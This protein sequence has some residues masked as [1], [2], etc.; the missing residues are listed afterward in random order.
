MAAALFHNLIQMNHGNCDHWQIESAGTWASPGQPAAYEVQEILKTM[1]IDLS[2]HRSR[3]VSKELLQNFCLILTMERGQKESLSIEF[4]EFKHR[5]FMLSEMSGVDVSIK[6]PIGGTIEDFE[7]GLNDI[8][9]WLSR[10]QAQIK[11]LARCN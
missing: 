8:S 7:R 1:G 6:D 2:D 9:G 5:I 11:L 10:G 4:P 3:C